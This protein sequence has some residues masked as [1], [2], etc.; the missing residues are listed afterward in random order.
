MGLTELAAKQRSA[1]PE[2]KKC[3]NREINPYGFA[4]RFLFTKIMERSFYNFSEPQY[5]PTV[6]NFLEPRY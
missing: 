5:L 2:L 4:R 1:Y 3:E 6:N